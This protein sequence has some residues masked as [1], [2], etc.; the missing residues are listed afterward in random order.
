M[1]NEYQNCTANLI[2]YAQAVQTANNGE[3]ALDAQGW[4]E[5]IAE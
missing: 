4:S 3:T 5:E 1:G 2:I